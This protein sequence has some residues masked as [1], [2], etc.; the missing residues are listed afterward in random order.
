[1]SAI[2]AKGRMRFMVFPES[3]DAGVVCRCLD[4]LAG[5]L[6]LQPHVV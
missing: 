6:I 5:H 1:M 2:S 3:F 4:R